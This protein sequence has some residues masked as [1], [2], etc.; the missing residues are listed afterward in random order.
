MP[1]E[2]LGIVEQ[3]FAEVEALS[4]ALRTAVPVQGRLSHA[5]RRVLALLRDAGPMTVPQVARARGTSRQNIQSMADRLVAAGWLE[6]EA[7]PD[8]RR[9]DRLRL[10]DAGRQVL[11]AANRHHIARL[12]TLA[13]AVSEAEV[14]TCLA[15]VRR[16]RDGLGGV[17]ARP[18]RPV[19][20][21]SRRDAPAVAK[22]EPP[23]APPEPAVE[24]GAEVSPPDTLPVNLL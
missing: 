18:Q 20:R 22:A 10:T 8:H 9:S 23:E 15:V 5:A 7:N 11:G 1:V 2:D 16:L 19:V 24:S 13:G 21:R 12:G 14:G 6:Y 17:G 3:L 4:T